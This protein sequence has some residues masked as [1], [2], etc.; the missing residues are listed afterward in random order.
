MTE[1]RYQDINR[2]SERAD[3]DSLRRT[4]QHPSR[5]ELRRT[6]ME[7]ALKNHT[8]R[9]AVLALAIVVA[10]LLGYVVMT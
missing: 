8:L 1:E 4:H 10:L 7:L 5:W 2:M 9:T 3:L 6:R